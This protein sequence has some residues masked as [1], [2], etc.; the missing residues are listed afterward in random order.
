[1]KLRSFL[2]PLQAVLLTVLV[3]CSSTKV[4]PPVVAITESTPAI[5]VSGS[6]EPAAVA[7]VA[8]PQI[9][10]P[11]QN[12][13]STYFDFDKAELRKDAQGVI[14]ANS[15]YLRSIGATKVRVEGHADERG[16]RE[17]NL[18]LG[19]KRAETAR[20][21]LEV[22]GVPGTNMEALSYGKEK[23]MDPGHTEAAWAKN[24]RADIVY[25]NPN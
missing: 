18:A 20:R 7:P 12:Y 16:S 22:M 11:D 24:R 4:T 13:R 14:D 3:G 9:A 21:A 19:Q 1:M 8:S 17:Y 23:P 5:V 10:R 15:A 6:P 25:K 2:L